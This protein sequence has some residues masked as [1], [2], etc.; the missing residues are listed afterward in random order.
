MPLTVERDDFEIYSHGASEGASSR[1]SV[2]QGAAQK[3]A[4][5]RRSFFIFSRAVFYAARM[6]PD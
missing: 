4:S 5:Y 2:S 6:R 1:R 3:T